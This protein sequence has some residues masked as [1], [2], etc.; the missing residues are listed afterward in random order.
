MFE[1]VG[2]RGRNLN[3]KY[4]EQEERK[5]RVECTVETVR[6]DTLEEFA[7]EESRHM[8]WELGRLVKVKLVFSY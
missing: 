8:G 7:G 3:V 4:F 6:V 5:K 1:I 2:A